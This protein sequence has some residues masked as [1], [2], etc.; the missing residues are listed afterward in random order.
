MSRY[1]GPN[2]KQSRRVGFSLLESG[3]DLKRP[4]G[5]GQ[6]GKDRKKKP[7]NYSIQLGEEQKLRFM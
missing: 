1:T 5:P 6:H 4:F 2:N 7:S 3:K